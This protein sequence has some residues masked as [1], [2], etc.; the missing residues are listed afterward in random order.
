MYVA[1]FIIS[2]W[3]GIAELGAVV[4]ESKS[5]PV[6]LRKVESVIWLRGEP[7]PFERRYW[8][9]SLEEDVWRDDLDL[10]LDLGCTGDDPGDTEEFITDRD[11]DDPEL[12]CDLDLDREEFMRDDILRGDT[13]ADLLFFAEYRFGLGEGEKRLGSWEGCTSKKGTS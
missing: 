3:I 12:A 4:T 8:E 6:P 5:L 11:L 9:G 13:D 7:D 10:D 1:A 2:P